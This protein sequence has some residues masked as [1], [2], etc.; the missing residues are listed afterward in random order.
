MPRRRRRVAKW[1]LAGL[2]V[3][4][5]GAAVADPAVAD[6]VVR[7][8]DHPGY[9]RIVFA[10][11]KKIGFTVTRD[12]DHVIIR[13]DSP[14]VIP[15]AAVPS[16]VLAYHGD[17][18]LADLQ[19]APGA[20]L[21][22]Q[23]I[24]SRVVID[25][26][27]AELTVPTASPTPAA[28][29]AA[30]PTN[31]RG[32][33]G[34]IVRSA[35][36]APGGAEAADVG[37]GI[38]GG[39]GRPGPEAAA[40]T[41]LAPGSDTVPAR[42]AVSP[43]V[44]QVPLPTRGNVDAVARAV[45]RALAAPV[46]PIAREP[47]PAMTADASKATPPAAAAAKDSADQAS[48]PQTADPQAPA[49]QAAA[50]VGPGAQPTAPMSPAAMLNG[51]LRRKGFL[52]GLPSPPLAASAAALQPNSNGTEPATAGSAQAAPATAG[53]APPAGAEP[54]LDLVA[55]V[56][57]PDATGHP[58]V[59]LPFAR[60]TGAAAFRRGEK[61]LVVFDERRPIDLA[62]LHAD[63][64]EP[65]PAVQLLPD[66]TLVTVPVPRDETLRLERVPQGWVIRSSA[67]A[68]SSSAPDGATTASAGAPADAPVDAA[69][70]AIV[71]VAADGQIR[72]SLQNPG[73]SI[74]VPD[75][76]T[77]SNL[78]VGTQRRDGGGPA[79]GVPVG[80]HSP[81]YLLLVSVQG[82]A[83]EPV[84]DRISLRAAPDG[85]RLEADGADLLP[86]GAANASADAT[87]SLASAVLTRHFDFPA[88]SVAD[89][90]R[91]MDATVAAAANAPPRA[92]LAPRLAA[93]QV[94][95]ALGLGPEAQALL[96]VAATDDPQAAELPD[97][98][99]LSAIGGLL[100][101]RD[102]ATHALDDARLNGFDD[103]AFWRAVAATI[104]PD[105][106]AVAAPA[107]AATMP[108][109][110]SYPAT[111]SRRL[112]PLV[113]ETLVE[114]GATAAADRLLA[115]NPTAPELGLARGMLAEAHG[116]VDAA[117]AAYDNLA[118]GHDRLISARAGDHAIALRLRT[119][120]IDAAQAA[121]AME[122]SLY[123]WRETARELPMRR[124]IAELRAQA[125]AWRPALAMLRETAQLFPDAADSLH[126]E[127]HDLFAAM[128]QD[129][130]AVGALDLVM[131]ADENADLMQ[132]GEAGA[133]AAM[134]LAD[135]L[136]TLDLPARAIPL[137]D[138]LMRG[139]G[140]AK[141]K[142]ELGM[143]LAAVRWG[144][145]DADGTLA[146]LSIS[147]APDLP[148][149]L[150][151]SRLLLKAR[152]EAEKGDVSLA[153]AQLATLGTDEGDL[154]RAELASAAKD[155]AAAEEALQA[156]VVR[157]PAT[158]ARL[159]QSDQDVLLRL[160]GAAAQA[161]DEAQ[162]A[163]LQSQAGRLD[164]HRAELFKMLVAPPVSGVGDLPRAAR[165]A[166]AARDV[167]AQLQT[168]AASSH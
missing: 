1:G 85:F 11:D 50:T 53:S 8:A 95:I 31:A 72:L 3:Y 158:D 146:S 92:R 115:R 77:G 105:G 6:I 17:V 45:E 131:I 38:V 99:A 93:A 122:N 43:R 124:K 23:Q 81:G 16:H 101:G 78:L 62:P 36:V 119:G 44:L 12:G 14:E 32:A 71:P 106:V 2:L 35:T 15:G 82:I 51:A 138:R 10:F 145:A 120:R 18:G 88:R 130:P 57:P 110:S 126:A 109:L 112:L 157:M 140:D 166:A 21:E 5:G 114:G 147:D 74:V 162:L 4:G 13:F 61:F 79:Q 133:K 80:R 141:L 84:S 159:P 116:D 136:T 104:R 24:D 65:A 7:S 160:A 100:E 54:T 163:R 66:A 40:A 49:A 149:D 150:Q 33:S 165:E 127:L 90:T 47:L 168:L 152:A 137:L 63:P 64:T 30:A 89:L 164:G 143:R 69:D 151:Q 22:T 98:A 75:R 125:H 76:M 156:V 153:L 108:I 107:F 28:P 19:L 117:L 91:L 161:G 113:A 97:L 70:D 20:R 9:G 55:Q 29:T 41:G 155:W 96:R 135:R 154:L 25:V 52:P 87:V 144:Q 123:A 39:G 67:M 103:I 58:G 60:G 102:D 34:R 42:H 129:Q 128:L 111:L 86:Q 73:R 118:A 59:L 83:V 68:G 48:G 121:D 148:P 27:A 26:R 37:D 139:A 46:D 167:P 134:L 56:L 142:A 94:M 132:Q